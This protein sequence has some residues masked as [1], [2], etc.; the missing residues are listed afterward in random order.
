M[1]HQYTLKTDRT[2]T[3][4]NLEHAGTKDLMPFAIQNTVSE[5]ALSIQTM[6]RIRT[7][8]QT[9]SLSLLEGFNFGRL[10]NASKL[11][12]SDSEQGGPNTQ[13]SMYIVPMNVS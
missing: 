4:T 2:M 7:M 9:P 6:Q 1:M 3:P 5:H 13:I 12:R 10:A 11:N 8:C